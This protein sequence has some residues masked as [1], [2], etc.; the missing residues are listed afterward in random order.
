MQL[1]QSITFKIEGI[2]NYDKDQDY[3]KEIIIKNEQPTG[4]LIL[5]KSIVLREDVDTS[6]IN[7]DDLS[8]IEFKLIA[9]EDIVDLA[10]GSIIY[11]KGKEIKTYNLDKNGY[12]KIENLPIGIYGIKEIKT[13]EGLV[14]NNTKYEV[15]FTAKDHVTKVYEQKLDI[16]NKSTIVEFSKQ[17]ITGEKTLVGAKLIILNENNEIIDKWTSTEKTHKI[18][19]LVAGKKY[20]L[21][22]EHAPEGYIIAKD[23][24]FTLSTKDETQVIVM[25]DEPILQNIRV[26]KLD[27]DTNEV[28]RSKFRFAIYEDFECK[29]LIKEVE[30]N[31][32]SG[33]VEF[34]A[35]KYGTY[36]IKETQ[37]PADYYLSEKIVE[38]EIN[39]NG[40]FVDDEKLEE[41][42]D[43]YSLNFYNTVIPIIQT[44]NP[45]N[46][47][48]LLSLA[49]VSIIGVTSGIII[50]KSRFI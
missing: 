22:E 13:L 19:G 16:E 11:E 23:I 30:S 10:D 5:S 28:I 38:I 48:L 40:I 33:T 25:K 15:K 32:K 34:K 35:L 18:E 41:K 47:I 39:K 43:F 27:K 9:E 1:G 46:N 14:L 12:L 44:G 17:D 31:E 26:V 49:C 29:K 8:G 3:I 42:E 2:K 37:A 20:I 4:T 50:L 45:T 36:Y 24:E 7:I 21:R 6:L